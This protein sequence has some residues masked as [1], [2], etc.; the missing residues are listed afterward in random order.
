IYGNPAYDMSQP[1]M[2]RLQQWNPQTISTDCAFEVYAD[3][4]VVVDAQARI[5]RLLK[6]LDMTVKSGLINP[7]PIIAEIVELAGFDPADVVMQQPPSKGPEPLNVSFRANADALRDPIALAMLVKTNQA[8]G[9]QDLD[10]AKKM[11][12]AAGPAPV[13]P[14][15]ALKAGVIP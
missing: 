13:A 1:D 7:A 8:P 4:T 6:I 11:I 12:A 14:T 15:A 9:P 5:E 3:S 10:A 2:Q